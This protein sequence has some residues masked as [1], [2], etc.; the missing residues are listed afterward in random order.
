VRDA[1]G[2]GV[3]LAERRI[4]RGKG[5]G[6]VIVV[7]SPQSVPDLTTAGRRAQPPYD[8]MPL[9][10]LAGK[11]APLIDAEGFV[12]PQAPPAIFRS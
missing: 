10:E 3:L 7:A 12:T 1:V 11:A 4:F 5:F 2:D 8:V 6:N 9:S